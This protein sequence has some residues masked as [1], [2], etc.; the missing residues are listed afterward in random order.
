MT[1]RIEPGPPAEPRDRAS[2]IEHHRVV[3]E[4]LP[5]VRAAALAWRN[6]VAGLLAGLLGFSLIR[7]RSDVTALEQ[8]YAAIV[9]GLLLLALIQGGVAAFLLLRA[10][11]G[12]PATVALRQ[13]DGSGSTGIGLDHAETLA[14]IRALRAGLTLAL[15]AVGLL[16]AA[17]ATT[18]YG[19]VTS[20]DPRLDVLMP[21][22]AVCGTVVEVSRG[23]LTLDT[24]HGRV[25]VP[26]NR[27]LS[28]HP[29]KECT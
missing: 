5:R 20:S 21:G 22:G 9:G 25:Q 4:E 3:A 12:R 28:L 10:A 13:A 2:A 6:G 11:H 7:G 17:V 18:W 19:P 29:V 1:I 14:A 16:C 15:V 27:A 23:S 24:E 8:P 26:L